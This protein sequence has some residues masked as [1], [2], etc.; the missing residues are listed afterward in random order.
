M[1]CIKHTL[2]LLERSTLIVVLSAVLNVFLNNGAS[3]S[4]SDLFIPLHDFGELARYK[5]KKY[6]RNRALNP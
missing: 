2:G 1:W 6:Y 3:S 4:L 5:K